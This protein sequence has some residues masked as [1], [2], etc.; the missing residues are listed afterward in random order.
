MY[1]N[2][3]SERNKQKDERYEEKYSGK[4]KSEGEWLM[5]DECTLY[6]RLHFSGKCTR[7]HTHI[8][9]IKYTTACTEPN[10]FMFT[11]ASTDLNICTTSRYRQ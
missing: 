6:A 4:T 8:I 11:H 7:L 10:N 1:I 2:T 3:V 9:I 5:K